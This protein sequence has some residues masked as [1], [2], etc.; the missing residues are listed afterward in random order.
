M[1][2][3]WTED[4]ATSVDEIDNQHKEIFKKMDDLYLA[5]RRG[6]GKA[7]IAGF[8][9]FLEDYV[10]VHFDT[11]EKYMQQFAYPD[12]TSHRVQH[13]GFI[14]TIVELK[15]Q[16]LTD[17]PNLA[18]VIKTNLEISDWLKGHICNVDKKL[19]SFLK[20]RLSE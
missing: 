14:K 20:T 5:C 4:L 6:K 13:T 16:L 8:I 10:S 18:L 3:E 17:G 12:Y 15:R 2:I 7:E 11:E 19:G 9:K 1:A